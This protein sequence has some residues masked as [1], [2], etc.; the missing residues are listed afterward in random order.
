MSTAS[1]TTETAESQPGLWRELGGMFW[2]FGEVWSILAV[3]EK[4]ILLLSL[5][6]M[7]LNAAT[8]SAIP[9][10][11]G[12]MVNQLG[13]ANQRGTMATDWVSIALRYMIW[14]AVCALAREVFLL[15]RKRMVSAV[16]TTVERKLT[17]G[18]VSHLYRQS[19]QSLSRDQVGAVHGRATGGIKAF[20]HFI[21]LSFREFLPAAFAVVIALAYAFYYRPM[22]GCLLLLAS[23]C[24]MAVVAWQL[25]WQKGM[26]S[27]LG[28]TQGV[29]NSKIIE[30][31][32]GMEY[33][34]AANTL[35]V[36]VDRI[37]RLADYRQECDRALWARSSFF[38]IMKSLIEWIFYL[39][40]LG[41][42]VYLAAH[43]RIEVGEIV[44]FMGLT[45]NVTSPLRDMN[46]VLDDAFETSLSLKDLMVIMDELLDPSFAVDAEQEMTILRRFGERR[47]ATPKIEFKE[48][49]LAPDVPLLATDGLVVEFGS[50]KRRRRVLD[51]VTVQIQI[52]EMIGFA[53]PSGS[54]KSTLLKVLMRLVTPT[55]GVAKF[56]DV[57]IQNVSRDAIGRLIGYVSQNP[58]VISGTVAENIAYGIAGNPSREAIEQAASKAGLHEEILAM[59]GG[60][61]AAIFERGKNI[62]GGQRQRIAIAR[63]FLADPPVIILDEG[64]SALDNVTERHVQEA[65][66]RLRGRRTIMMVAHRLTTL[67]AA[68]R[69]LVFERG[70]IVQTGTMD[71]LSHMDGVFRNLLKVLEAE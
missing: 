2:R 1:L 60:Y 3:G 6:P 18:L 59:P 17:V 61:D 57:P 34:R 47:P 30:Q 11:A 56:G 42:T 33:I 9:I 40:V 71:E 32:E 45:N 10:L 27:E 5:I 36:E 49:K 46:R 48:P 19:L 68:D 31:L 23:C 55:E 25:R 35:G 15:M 29:L 69:I 70:R 63:V 66:E 22:I 53:G 12:Q 7:A 16:S 38:E 26:Y 20:I 8:Q 28:R 52:G 13:A 14:I 21:R 54:G 39:A 43:Q 65:L 24:V 51:D 50:R 67:R 58:F 37:A 62:S 4:R 44:A 41:L 64:T